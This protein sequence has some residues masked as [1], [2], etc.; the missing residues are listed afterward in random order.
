MQQIRTSLTSV[1]KKTAVSKESLASTLLRWS[2][3][4]TKITVR[5]IFGV[6]AQEVTAAG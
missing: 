6:R 2:T 3:V 5:R 4:K 1:G